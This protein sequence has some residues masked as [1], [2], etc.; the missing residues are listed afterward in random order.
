MKTPRIVTRDVPQSAF[1]QLVATGMPAVLARIY[2]ARGVAQP[3]QLDTSLAGLLP[4]SSLQH[5]VNMSALLADAIAAEKRLLIVADYDADGAT[6]CAVGIN[7]LRAFGAN[8]DYLVPNRFEYGYGLTPEI[9][10]QAATGK[11]DYLI[12]VDNG[13]A[14]VDGVEEARKAGIEVLITDHHLPGAE[15]PRAACIVNPNQATCTFASK[16]LAGVGVMFY[17][18]MG[19]RAELRRRGWFSSRAE[20]NLAE[21]LD[22]VALGTVAD[23]VRLDDNN[24]IL[25]DQGL[26]RIRAGR[27]RPGIRALFRAAGRDAARAS[28]YDLGFVAGPRLNAAGRLTDMSVGIECLLSTDERKAAELAAQLDA[29]NRE[30]RDIEAGM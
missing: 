17:V 7:A 29:L 6:A 3:S 28:T 22:L 20:P 8:V 25:V 26:K 18:M 10:R 27:A 23:V 14:S 11:P 13:I 16:N 24:R 1:E 2:A 4:M 21:L 12:T 30:R 15:L 19:L 5:C 9:V